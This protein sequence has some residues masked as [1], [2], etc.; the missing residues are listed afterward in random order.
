MRIGGIDWRRGAPRWWVVWA[1]GT[2]AVAGFCCLGLLFQNVVQGDGDRTIA[3][4]L[5]L[6]LSGLSWL[7][8][9]LVGLIRYDNGRL[10]LAAPL[11]VLCTVAL[12]LT[13]LPENLGWRL[14]KGSLEQAAADCVE[15]GTDARYGVY[16]IVG[17]ERYRGG[18]LFER[19][20]LL[21]GF[22][23]AY[24]PHGVP[25]SQGEYEYKFRPHEGDWYSYWR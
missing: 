3:L 8:C 2:A 1:L 24:M 20:G 17:V 11:L 12:V 18:C 25:E 10:S 21:A 16:T 22:G 13:G 14:S 23:Y 15:S 7:I 4:L 19:Q 6:L 5:I 9:G